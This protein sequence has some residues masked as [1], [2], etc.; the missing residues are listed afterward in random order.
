MAELIDI[1]IGTERIRV[2]AWATEDTLT[3]MLK[4]NEIAARALNKLVGVGEADGKSVKV[5]EHYFKQIAKELEQSKKQQKELLDSSKQDRK[6]ESEESKNTIKHIKSISS[7]NKDISSYVDNMS[8]AIATNN[9]VLNLLSDKITTATVSF[10]ELVKRVET[11]GLAMSGQNKGSFNTDSLDNLTDMF[12]KYFD[13]QEKEKQENQKSKANLDDFDKFSGKSDLYKNIE[14]MRKAIEKGDLKPDSDVLRVILSA[15]EEKGYKVKGFDPKDLK[16]IEELGK[17]IKSGTS[18]DSMNKTEINELLNNTL[19]RFKESG[20]RYTN[21]FDAFI[22]RYVKES[23]LDST[24]DEKYIKILSSLESA[25]NS[26]SNTVK[27]MFNG[28]FG[29]KGVADTVGKL[30]GVIPDILASVTGIKSLSVVGPMVGAALGYMASTLESLA[31]SINELMNVGASLG[32]SMVDLKNN[33]TD[34]G[35]NLENFA[36]LI[37]KNS[38]ALRILGNNTNEGMRNFALLGQEVRKISADYNY[39]GMTNTELN[40][41]IIQEIELRRKS[42]QTLSDLQNNLAAGFN[43]LLYETTAMAKITGQDRRE[44]LRA[45]SLAMDDKS[46][47]SYLRTLDEGQQSTFRSIN[48]M[49]GFLGEDMTMAFQRAVA[50]GLS[51]DTLMGGQLSLAGE[52]GQGI[53]DLFDMYEIS[54]QNGE[55]TTD[56]ITKFAAQ[57]SQLNAP[58]EETLR[59]IANVEGSYREQANA[60][61]GMIEKQVGFQNKNSQE[62]ANQMLAVVEELKAN[63]IA[64][65]PAAIEQMTNNFDAMLFRTM[66]NMLGF[67]ETGSGLMDGV[68]ELITLS[69]GQD[70]EGFIKNVWDTLPDSAKIVVGMASIIGLLTSIKDGIFGLG[71]LLTGASSAAG[72]ALGAAG[73]AA[74]GA[75]NAGRAAGAAGAAAQGSKFVSFLKW[76]PLVGDVA[77]GVSEGLETGSVGRG[78]FGGVGSF[79]GRLGMAAA[80]TA[81]TGIGGVVTQAAGGYAGA[82]VGSWL[83]DSLFGSD[84]SVSNIPIN[85]STIPISQG[86]DTVLDK[87]QLIA[88]ESMETNY[89]LGYILTQSTTTSLILKDSISV[90]A[91]TTNTWLENLNGVAETI[92]DDISEI[93]TNGG[94]QNNDDLI[95]LL[96]SSSQNTESMVALISETNALLQRLIRR[97]D[98]ISNN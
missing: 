94:I 85:D 53:R 78:I 7:N 52:F 8:T 34:L 42:G 5:Q 19:K 43:E 22:K 17:K 18:L 91:N 16:N 93:K 48:S 67:G 4:Y 95:D 57:Y 56:F 1:E 44:L 9:F 58:D 11:A 33:A 70:L 88:S 71:P 20:S 6:K 76:L 87:L 74:S 72:G 82:N 75:A 36:N 39:F 97:Y 41:A 50:S 29:L 24:K 14:N 79:L 31:K 26:T 68:R 30:A 28:N 61:L 96:S 49:V 38:S 46:I 62:L 84:P 80:G 59:T 2:P 27:S 66:D 15:I 63:D 12:K 10:D 40:E 55:D 98:E 32:S 83:Y 23:S 3:A 64:G 77:M 25:T 69:E 45:Q 92:R 21:I 90:H 35:M 54:V 65:M 86:Q 81:T 73:A 37:S 51:I 89:M 13:Q 47:T 60:I